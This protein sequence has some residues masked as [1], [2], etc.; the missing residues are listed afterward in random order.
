MRLTDEQIERLAERVLRRLQNDS[1]VQTKV[2]DPEIIR[3]IAA[4]ILKHQNDGIAVENEVRKL[5]DQYS[6][7]MSSGQIDTQQMYSMIRKQVAS[8]LKYE[9]DPE[10][11][12]THVSHLVHDRIY[13]DDLIDYADEDKA[14]RA[15]KQTL[16]QTLRAEDTL[17]QKVRDKIASLKREV[18]EGSPEWD[19]L[20]RKYMDE[21]LNKSG[22]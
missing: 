15:I 6:A 11:Q 3:A 10:E 20:Y 2:P 5:M 21:E 1:L 22:V 17:G 13:N 7:Q 16:H 19:V 18:Q 8:K 4:C 9:L 14:L 12:V